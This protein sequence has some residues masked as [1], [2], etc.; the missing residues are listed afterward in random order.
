[1]VVDEDHVIANKNDVQTAQEYL[2]RA[3]QLNDQLSAYEE[4]E[5]R[6]EEE[7]ER[8]RKEN[9]WYQRIYWNV[10]DKLKPLEK[11]WSKAKEL[12]YEN[13]TFNGNPLDLTGWVEESFPEEDH[14][15]FEDNYQIPNHPQDDL[16]L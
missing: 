2:N 10:V 11:Y 1:M 14:Y 15:Y 3:K 7:M 8:L 16:E 4:R 6:R 5:R 13:I 12:V 9:E